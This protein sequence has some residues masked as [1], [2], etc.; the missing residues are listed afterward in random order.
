[1]WFWR[2][3]GLFIKSTLLNDWKLIELDTYMEGLY[4]VSLD[5]VSQGIKI[6][7]CPCYLPPENSPWAIDCDLYFSQI[8]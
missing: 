1:M 8:R 2:W 3:V 5:N 7:L 4:I 6:V